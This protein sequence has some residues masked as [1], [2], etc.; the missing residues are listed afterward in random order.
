MNSADLTVTSTG[1]DLSTWGLFLAA[2][3]L[4]KFVMLLL[5]LASIWCWAIII[6]KVSSVRRERRFAQQF[7]DAFWAGGSLDEL[8]DETGPDAEGSMSKV[9]VAAMREWRRASARGL[10]SS[11]G[12]RP[13]AARRRAGRGVATT[14]RGRVARPR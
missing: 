4:V 11:G 1:S 6:E 5:V 12:A 2:D 13:T 9:F 7:E 8:Y 10:A 3:P 14:A